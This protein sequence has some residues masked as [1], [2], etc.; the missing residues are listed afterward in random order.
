MIKDDNKLSREEIEN[1]IKK[2]EKYLEEIN[3]HQ[4]KNS[5]YFQEL[6]EI[7]QLQLEIEE[8]SNSIDNYL[9]CLAFFEKQQDRL[10]QAAVLGV[11]GTVF[12][13]KGDNNK[14]INYY[15]DALK[16]YKELNQIQEEI[17]CLKGIGNCFMALNQLDDA[18]DEFLE[19]SAVCSDN[20][21]VYN[22]L[23]CLGNLVLIHERQEKWDVVYELYKK[24]LKAFKQINDNKG[25]IISYFNL[26]ILLKE[27]QKTEALRYFKKGTNVAID[28]NYSE[29]IIKGLS[30][31]GETL[32]YLGQVKDA[33]DEFIK[34]LYLAE[35]VNAKNAIIQ[36]T[37]LLKSFGL[38]EEDIE[39][40][41][42]SYK[43]AQNNT[44]RD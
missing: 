44:L 41:L 1:L 26:G 32:F 28:S 29:L 20:N 10:G 23:D 40:E 18:C 3:D 39:N 17:T 43:S 2:K 24:T 34:A 15:K 36:I 14:A 9:T 12:F 35:K 8:Y 4:G 19:C 16:I 6:G 42:T 27:Q 33:K 13:K 21:D 22:L 11:L 30:Y 31:I 38:G 37:V 7:A 5:V 25:I